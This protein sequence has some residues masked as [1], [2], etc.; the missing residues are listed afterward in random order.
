M[1]TLASL[2]FNVFFYVLLAISVKDDGVPLRSG[3]ASDAR[4]VTT[5]PAGTLLAVRYALS[6]E[7][8]PCYKVAAELEGKHYEGYLPAAAINGIDV[9]EK[10]RKDAA[11]IDLTRGSLAETGAASATSSTSKTEGLKVRAS[12]AAYHARELM[13]EG[14]IEE[15]LTILDAEVKR[16]PDVS[17]L[18]LAGWAAREADQSKRALEYWRASLDLEPNP[19]LEKQYN[20]L[21]R[22]VHAD[23]SSARLYGVRVALRFDSDAIP[24]EDARQMIAV[25]DETLAQVSQQLGCRIEDK[26]VTIAQTWDAYRSG[27]GVVE[28]SGGMY[29]GRI[30]VPFDK[31]KGINASRETL[32]HEATHAC[33]STFGN[34]PSWLHEGLAQKLSGRTVPAETLARLT[35][36]R[37]EGKLPPLADLAVG[38][39]GLNTE[40]ASLAYALALHAA[41]VM[42]REFGNDGIRNLLRNPERIPAATGEIEKRLA[43]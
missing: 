18:A 8:D 1:T 21:S 41:E 17:L 7:A 29:D 23:R 2:F 5:L 3:C 31:T 14:R 10:S 11:W 42:T 26:V 37:R 43:R 38:W 35:K 40:Q 19:E 12:A 39:S 34:L 13:E 15:S 9:I 25:V 28:W 36:M 22:E 16:K 33:L 32:A 24:V 27:M 6:G 4:I 30:R 20:E